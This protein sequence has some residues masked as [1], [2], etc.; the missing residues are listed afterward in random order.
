[1]VNGSLA[2]GAA[3][4]LSRYVEGAYR[5]RLCRTLGK[6]FQ[7]SSMRC[8]TIW[9]QAQ[10]SLYAARA[11]TSDSPRPLSLLSPASRTHRTYE[12]I[13]DDFNHNHR[14]IF[15]AHSFTNEEHHQANLETVNAYKDSKL[16]FVPAGDTPTS[17]RLFD[18]MAAGCIPVLMAPEEDILPN[19]PF[20][21]AIDWYN[22]VL[23][24]GRLSCSAVANATGTIKW[25][26]SL[27]APEKAPQL[28]CLRKRSQHV[29][30]NYLSYR[31][32]GVVSALLQELQHDPR[33]KPLLQVVTGK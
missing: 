30:R 21:T 10:A 32:A 27:L 2:R 26:E 33:H 15:T 1:M 3:M 23:L 4:N 29:F 18:A 19:L 14:R 31:E 5:D 12:E 8:S 28:D 16:C 7:S 20:P 25:L 24:G 6:A 17:R 11:Q 22:T 9:S 13:Y